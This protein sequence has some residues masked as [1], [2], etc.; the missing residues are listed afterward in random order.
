MDSSG[1]PKG[2]SSLEALRD[3]IRRLRG[4]GGCPWDRAQDLDNLKQYLLEECYEVVEA[5]E[6]R[7]FERLEEELGDLLFHILFLTHLAEEKGKFT[8]EDIVKGI[9]EKMV[10]RHPHVFG[11]AIAEDV[12]SVKQNWWK[13]KQAE[14]GGPQS[15]L[16]SIP[17]ALPALHRAYALGK[18]ASQVGLDWP[19]EEAVAA[20]VLEEFEELSHAFHQGREEGVEEELGDLL[21]AVAN[22]ARFLGINPEET[23]QRSNNKFTARF[24]T[25]EKTASERGKNINELSADEREALWEE[26]KHLLTKTDP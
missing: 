16:D 20:K 6:E 1:Q 2:G 23:L 25:M 17:R 22:L 5:I 21:F 19:N 7:S 14:K 15:L 8:L 12:S 10:R 3:L 13:I 26:V 11:N 18:R 24:R 9:L 4:P